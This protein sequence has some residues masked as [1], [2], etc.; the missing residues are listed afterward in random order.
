MTSHQDS[1]PSSQPSASQ[2]PPV[3][4]AT[5]Q[6]WV[7]CDKA[8][9][10]FNLAICS[11]DE[12]K[13][14]FREGPLR[15][16]VRDLCSMA[17]DRLDAACDSAHEYCK[18]AGASPTKFGDRLTTSMAYTKLGLSEGSNKSVNTGHIIKARIKS[19]ILPK[20]T[21]IK[22]TEEM[23]GSIAEATHAAGIALIRAEELDAGELVEVMT[24]HE[25]ILA[26]CKRD[27]QEYERMSGVGKVM[28]DIEDKFS[29][30][31]SKD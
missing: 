24:A 8:I 31:S 26:K 9:E 14:E 23:F 29:R 12:L 21:R 28:A 4:T 18:T 25:D 30:G 1:N 17:S 6:A 2:F 15:R 10:I 13:D 5:A 11:L 16:P 20:T 7:N 22:A 27:W 19:A 3:S